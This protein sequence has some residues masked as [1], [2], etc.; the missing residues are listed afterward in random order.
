MKISTLNYFLFAL[1]KKFSCSKTDQVRTNFSVF[2]FKCLWAL[3]GTACSISY[4]ANEKAIAQADKSVLRVYSYKNKEVETSGSSFVVGADN[5]VATNFHVIRGSDEV[6]LL[7]K[8]SDDKVKQL[9]AKI[10]WTSVDYD[11]ALLKVPDL[12][13]EPLIIN[14]QMPAKGSFVT[15]IGYPGIADRDE[16][17]T[18]WAESTISQGVIGRTTMSSWRSNGLQLNILQHS[19]AINQ[20]NSGGPLL[21]SCGRVVGVNTRKALSEVVGRNIVVQ[22][23]GIYYASHIA[24]LLDALKQQGI[25]VLPQSQACPPAG[26]QQSQ[27]TSIS[28]S[29]TSLTHKA[30]L[31]PTAIGAA[32][33]LSFGSLIF[34]LRKS[35]VVT[36][37]FTQYK[38]RATP[39]KIENRVSVAISKLVLR[40]TDSEMRP[41]KILI[42]LEQ[43]K[44]SPIYIG[45]DKAVSQ[46]VIDDATVSRRHASLLWSVGELRLT[47]LNSTNGTSVDGSAIQKSAVIIRHGQ[48]IK[49]GKVILSVEVS[50]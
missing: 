39:P 37:T 13:L 32:L 12:N 6:F 3:I 28:T 19:A 47:D 27:A 15:A 35:K 48:T 24:A 10:L 31:L 22:T 50:T 29:S 34:S 14:D 25:P 18:N 17:L 41:I 4:A 49:L 20:G 36:E 16:K 11:L 8:G 1:Q 21:D 7:V 9:K 42:D 23:E 5:I 43:N 45:R 38:R 2:C 30:W 46:M 44:N 26:P 33:F 40:G